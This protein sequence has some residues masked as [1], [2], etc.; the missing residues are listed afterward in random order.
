MKFK[1]L[2]AAL[3]AGTLLSGAASAQDKSPVALSRGRV[4]GLNEIP[5]LRGPIMNGPDM[6]SAPISSTRKPEEMNTVLR[7]TKSSRL[8]KVSN[9]VDAVNNAGKPLGTGSVGVIGPGQLSPPTEF[10]RRRGGA[11]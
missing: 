4:T 7:G 10:E 2:G 3:I 8:R 9:R 6:I 11:W 5:Q 1:A